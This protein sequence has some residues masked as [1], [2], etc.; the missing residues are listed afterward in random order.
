MSGNDT[1]TCLSNLPGLNNAGSNTSGLLVAAIMITPS[2]VSKP[3]ISTR[4]WFKVCSLSSLPPPKPAPLLLPTASISSINM[5]HGEF[6]LP[7]SNMSLTRDA[8]TPTNISTKSEPEIVKKGTPASPAIALANNV[9]PVPGGPTKRQ[10]LGIL[11]PRRLNFLGSFKNSTTSSTSSFASS[12]P[13]TSLKV[14]FPLISFIN[15]AFDF[16]KP[17]APPRPPC[18]CLIKN[19]HTAISKSIGNQESN[20][21]NREGIFSSIGEAEILTPLSVKV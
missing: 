15:F 8:P 5:I 10:P 11:P 18:I 21:P 3:S 19:I 12:T 1:T 14:T 20:T 13:A 6:F 4:S 2:L 17:I 9:F 7:C 16:P